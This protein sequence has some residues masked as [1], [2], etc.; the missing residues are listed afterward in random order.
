MI[1]VS[2]LTGFLGSGKT[3]V[4][5]RLLRRPEFSRTA[6]IINEFGEVG[7]DHDLVEASDESLVQLQTGC[8]CCAV[9]GDLVRTLEDLLRRR[10]EGTVPPFERVLIETSGLADPAPI[11]QSLMLD[12]ALAGRLALHGVVTT[13]DAVNGVETLRRQ[14]ESVKQVAVADRLLLT[15]TDLVEGVQAVRQ[16]V[17]A[18][19]PSAPVIVATLGEVNPEQLFAVRDPVSAHH[20][21]EHDD[22]HHAETHASNIAFFAIVREEPIAAIALTLFLE[23]LAEHCG[24][25]L[26]RLKGIIRVTENADR[27]AVIHGVQHVFH[28]PAWL[29]RWSTADRT[30][31]LVFITRGISRPWIEAL[32]AAIEAE[33][34][35]VSRAESMNGK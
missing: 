12:A 28:P 9:R 10:E 11:L 15:K 23:A 3:T 31:R 24:A 4:L 6:V 17:A 32:L 22:H 21:H 20:H 7:L 35:S 5:A 34:Q 19:N 2:V 25:D 18:I 1:P 14:P 27:P 13:V 29:E 30:S 8:L 33:V 26:L 16:Q